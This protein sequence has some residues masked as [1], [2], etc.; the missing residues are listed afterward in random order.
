MSALNKKVQITLLTFNTQ[1]IL[2]TTTEFVLSFWYN[3]IVRYTIF[4][5]YVYLVP[6]TLLK[7][8]F[9]QQQNTQWLLLMKKL[10]QDLSCTSNFE[11]KSLKLKFNCGPPHSVII[12]D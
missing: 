2:S 1:Y 5:I 11:V 12:P 9:L 7:E 10:N 8:I 3:Y 6:S 4:F